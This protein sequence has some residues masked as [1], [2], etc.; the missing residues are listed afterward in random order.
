MQ[1][2]SSGAGPNKN[3]F[4]ERHVSLPAALH[5]NQEIARYSKLKQYDQAQRSFERMLHNN[6]HPDVVTYNTMINV[7]VKSQ[8]LSD[9]LKL[10]DQM[11]KENIQPTIVTYTSLI[12]GCGKC[13]NFGRALSIYQSVKP[14]GIQLN[15]HFF[16]A[17]LN[18]TFL[19]GNLQ[20]VDMIL[21]DIK[22]SG[23]KPNTVTYNTML[24]GYIR[25]GLLSRMK[26]TIKEMVALNVQFSPVTQTTILQAVQLI[27]DHQSL[28]EFMELLSTVKFIPTKIQATQAILDLITA[29]K[30]VLAQQFLSYLISFGCQFNEEAYVELIM[31]AGEL[32][33]FQTIHWTLETAR[34]H[35]YNLSLHAYVAQMCS[36]AS[37]NNYEHTIK[38]FDQLFQ[39]SST[40]NDSNSNNNN[41]SSN[42]HF[43][44]SSND[45]ANGKL[46]NN[47]N[48]NT[49]INNNNNDNCNKSTISNNNID[50]NG[51]KQSDNHNKSNFNVTSSANNKDQNGNSSAESNS[52][53]LSFSYF[54]PNISGIYQRS[55]TFSLPFYIYSKLIQCFLANE[56]LDR[57]D[58]AISELLSSSKMLTEKES[59]EIIQ[60]YFNRSL[61]EKILQIFEMFHDQGIKFGSKGCNC[62]I[63][64]ALKIGKMSFIQMS[65]LDLSPT[66]GTLVEL[67]SNCPNDLI[68]SIQWNKLL[69]NVKDVPSQ[70]ALSELIRAMEIKGLSLN[71]WPAFRHF[72][73]IGAEVNEQIINDVLRI[74]MRT[75]DINSNGSSDS[76]SQQNLNSSNDNNN[77]NSNE[78]ANLI[79][80][81]DT[82]SNSNNINDPTPND[83]NSDHIRNESNL[84][85]IFNDSNSFNSNINS[86]FPNFNLDFQPKSNKYQCENNFHSPPDCSFSFKSEDDILFLLNISKEVGV[87]VPPQLYSMAVLAAISNGDL[88]TAINLKYE[89]EPIGIKLDEK[90]QSIFDEHCESIKSVLPAEPPKVPKKQ[91]PRRRS[92]T[93]PQRVTN[94]IIDEMQ[95]LSTRSAMIALDLDFI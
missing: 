40:N 30:L 12:D 75:T 35:G 1:S 25:F 8:R 95:E 57:S 74:F 88:A 73:M 10:F 78:K 91:N 13:N 46:N 16:N 86:N 66:V 44:K 39:L 67:V 4:S 56:D 28:I 87:Q 69:S 65:I 31:L 70:S 92:R 76:E 63:Q 54:T 72:V 90:A 64:S 55:S 82:K 41:N 61:F 15:M 20:T 50:S 24:S 62:V 59:D 27:K 45:D 21:N 51:G 47:N 11:K 94:P 85:K 42:D 48:N 84:K 80:D 33:N 29:R 37:F 14:L 36:L 32:S 9:A 19:K 93:Y 52:S 5:F 3:K 22:E 60:I 89:M 7:Y 53:T 43:N 77:S 83:L 34:N 71:V 17:I 38:M 18:A 2:T 26:P 58:K 23:L 79:D 49:N 81:L 6:V 68:S